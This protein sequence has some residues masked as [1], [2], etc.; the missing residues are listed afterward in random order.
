[1]T[2]P[3]LPDL[4]QQRA[5]QQ[6]DATAF[7]FIDYEIDPAGFADSLTWSQMHRRALA[8]AEE[9]R[10]CGSVGDRAAILAP[11]GLDYVAAFLGALQA[12]FIAVPLPVP[13]FGVHDERVSS[14]L[15][16]CSPSVVLTTSSAVDEVTKYVRNENGRSRTSIVELDLL[17]LDAPRELDPIRYSHPRDGIPPVHVGIDP[18]AGRRRHFA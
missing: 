16:D 13:L 14:A 4:L 3:S 5:S 8:V 9:L 11:E 15:L 18:P 17:D 2:Q 1:M 6:A 10:L 7:T 12:G